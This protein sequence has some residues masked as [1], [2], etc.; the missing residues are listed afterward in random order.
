MCGDFKYNLCEKP[1][2]EER[3]PSATTDFLKR[4]ENELGFRQNVKEGG[5]C[6]EKASRIFA[7]NVKCYV[8]YL[9]VSCTFVKV[10]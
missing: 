10:N 7:K 5:L 3:K 4:M 9:L 8:D 1:V 2:M 6:S